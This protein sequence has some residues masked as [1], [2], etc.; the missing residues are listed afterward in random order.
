MRS[1]LGL[2]FFVGLAACGG[3]D[4]SS[5]CGPSG[6][7]A[8]TDTR[9]STSG[10]LCASLSAI[11][12][13]TVQLTVDSAAKTFTWSE[14]GHQFA[15]SIDL[16]TCQGTVTTTSDTPTADPSVTITTTAV[17]NVQF[18]G[19]S[20]TGALVAN[21]TASATVTG[22]PCSANYTTSGSRQ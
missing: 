2:L 4:S 17:R 7:W 11:S 10:G 3:S 5:T 6:S 16:G 22:L 13:G 1:I 18:S 9:T 15:G 21:V 19:N 20:V 12:P 8:I 14:S